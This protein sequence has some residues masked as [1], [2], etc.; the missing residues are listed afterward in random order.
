MYRF[1][2][3]FQAGLEYNPLAD[4]VGALVNWR[5]VEETR[6]RPAVI[7]GTS[8][9]RIGTDDGRAY[10]GTLSK[11]L[12]GLVGLPVSPYAGVAYGESD[13]EWV[14]IG[15]LNVRWPEGIRSTHLYDGEHV[16][17]VVSRGFQNWTLG[18]V[19]AEQEDGHHLGLSVGL[20]F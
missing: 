4:D 15:G 14:V 19:L 9:D 12:G 7:L 13:E 16:H 6:R 18:V 11:D 20:D 2:P 5:V 1:H 17:H 3:R 10:F 8:S